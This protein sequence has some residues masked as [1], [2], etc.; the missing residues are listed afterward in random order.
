MN[1][2]RLHR[3]ISR[4]KKE[5]VKIVVLAGRRKSGKDVC[6]EYLKRHYGGFR[7]VRI[8]ETPN[9][10]A[11]ILGLEI[12]RGVQQALFGVNA[13]LYPVIG[14]SAYKRRAALTLDREKPRRAIVEAVRTKEEYEEFVVKRKGILIGVRAKPEVRYERALVNAQIRK[15]K[16]DEAKMTFKE[17]MAKE[18]VPIERDIDWIVERAH[19]IVDNN[20]N[21]RR[22]LYRAIDTIM[23][24]LGI[25]KRHK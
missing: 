6:G 15:E 23:F 9:K 4:W 25:K 5:K 18:K 24:R 20:S 22:N 10:I 21:S 2:Q 14:E 19:F 17:F 1:S 16:R 12:T 3:E 7:H 11:K 13:L 8:A